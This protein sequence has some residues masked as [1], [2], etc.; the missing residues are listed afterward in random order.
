MTAPR[1]YR[2]QLSTGPVELYARTAAAAIAAALEL[3]SPDASVVR[4]CQLGQW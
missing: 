1:P 3:A 4:V 2:V